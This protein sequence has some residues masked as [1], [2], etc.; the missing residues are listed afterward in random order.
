MRLTALVV[1]HE[2]G[3]FELIYWVDFV[4]EH[5][6]PELDPAK[7]TEDVEAELGV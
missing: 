3:R 6:L 1:E 7:A 5:P 2:D 4:R